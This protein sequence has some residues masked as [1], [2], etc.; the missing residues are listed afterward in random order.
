MTISTLHTAQGVGLSQRLTL[1]LGSTVEQIACASHAELDD[2]RAWVRAPVGHPVEWIELPRENWRHVKPKVNDAVMFRYRL[3]GDWVKSAFAIAASIA[4]SIAVPFLAPI[5][6]TVGAALAGA[7]LGIGASLAINALFPA[8]QNQASFSSSVANAP[9]ERAR[10]F[11]NVES[12]SNVLAK[13]A[14][15]PVVVGTRRI[16]PPEI[17]QPHYFLQDGQ[18]TINR[19][20]ALDGHHDI[21]DVQVD[22]AP[23]TDYANI[24]TEIR[25]GAETT[26]VSTFI[27]KVTKPTGI[28]D[29]LSTFSLD[30][31]TLVDQETPSNS[32]PTWVRFTTITDAKLEEITLRLQ[33]D[34]FI[35]TDSPTENIRVPVR[36][37]LRPKGSTGA[38]LNGPEIHF[39]G[40]D[41]S[42]SLKEVRFRWDGVFGDD[43]PGGSIQ[44]EFFQRVPAAG[45][46]LSDE[47]TGDQWQ[48]D[49]SFV[50][51]SGLRDVANVQG[52]RNG[53]RITLDPAVFPQ[54]EYEW[55]VIRGIAVSRDAL[56]SSTYVL[57]GA[58]NSLFLARN[59][60][61]SWQVPVDQGSFVGR[62]TVQQA[63]SI[64]GRQPCQRPSVALIAL[65][66]K[67]QSVRSVTALASRYV[68]DWDGT[69][70]NTLTTTSNPATHYRQV[71]FDYMA[72]HGIRTD[73]IVEEQFVGW[74]QECIDR[75]YE[76]SAVF[77]GSSVKDTLDGIAMAG[78]AR[79]RYSD[80]FGIDWFR[81]RSA[82]RPVTAFSP[83]NA[84]INLQWV[85][86]EKPVGIR[87]NFQNADRDYADDEVQINNPFYS[88][89]SGY[90]V[91]SYATIAKP[92]LIERRAVF[93]MAQAHYQGRRAIIVDCSTEGAICDRGDLVGIVTDLMDD[94]HSGARIRK[95]IDSTTFTYDQE[96]PTESTTSLFGVPNI[97]DPANIFTVGEQ[98]VVL[99]STPTGTEMRTIVAALETGDGWTIRVDAP[100]TSTDLA[101]AHFVLGPVSRFMTR[102]I[103]SEVKR[104]GQENA[105]LVLVDEAPEIFQTLQERFAS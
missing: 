74:R 68:M 98:S 53:I 69:G 38:W 105:Q 46:A 18:Q 96:I 73:L 95:V 7:A 89:F 102:C 104:Q 92:A 86:S 61:A 87:A 72:Y 39:V 63:T 21:T 36:F 51:G 55:E 50:S 57:G 58:V 99:V 6:G 54:V 93:D 37:R 62:I 56:N 85:M 5:L 34:S 59:I 17:A 76:V 2:V 101:G 35:K 43:E 90:D 13:E 12:G 20:F 27:T 79:P 88:N 28:S 97:F 9:Q 40:R 82:E 44:Y 64:V 48:A 1:P 25:N 78:Y 41:V 49:A 60:G 70:W 100:F 19:I 23:I 30:A 4:I 33:L 83:R 81:D 80:G 24:T 66:A 77:A 52:R 45:Y 29:T 71:L 65:Q 22:R 16:S 94:A 3:H 103:V 15:L 14:Y 67:G 75:G 11:S 42:T 31:L 26:S 8:Q 32:E 84:S 47:S 10:Q 91:R